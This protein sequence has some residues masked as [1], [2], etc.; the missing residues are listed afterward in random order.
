L[1]P[2][3]NYFISDG[4]LKPVIQF[5]ISENEGGIYEVI[6]IVD[7]VPLF[8]EEHIHR[9]FISA[10]LA[11]KTIQLHSDEIQNQ[12]I[13]LIAANKCT[14]GNVL[15]SCKTKL[16]MFFIPHQYPDENVYKTGVSTCILNAE[17]KNPNAK[18]FQ[19]E[20]RKKTDL[21]IEQ[22]KL[23]EVLLEDNLGKITEGSRSNVFFVKGNNVY[24]PKA[25]VVL[26]GITR[27]K[28]IDLIKKADFGF[29]ECDIFTNKLSDFDAA[30]ITGTSP[31][32]LPIKNIDN[33]RFATG[34]M[35]V[36]TL[37]ENFNELIEDYV[38]KF[39]V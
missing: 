38:N 27:E 11:Q 14:T 35:V 37:I 39:K 1:K 4:I 10:R 13:Q 19:T 2:V 7:G 12:I 23:F 30:F 36:Q 5:I 24:T 29:I 33:Y 28:T 17:R 34:N 16:K 20:V 6:R 18:V 32:I 15:I 31:K 22:R 9:F 26:K 8:F 21:L 3:H 25:N